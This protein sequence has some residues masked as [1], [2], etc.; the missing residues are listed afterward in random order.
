[1]TWFHLWDTQQ[2][3]LESLI[4]IVFEEKITLCVLCRMNYMPTGN[5]TLGLNC[6]VLLSL[7]EALVAHDSPSF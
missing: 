2:Q 6:C 1:M 3:D 5:V 4:A 7:V